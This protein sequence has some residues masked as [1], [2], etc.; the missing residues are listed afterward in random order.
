MDASIAHLSDDFILQIVKVHFLASDGIVCLDEERIAPREADVSFIFRVLVQDLQH[1][2]ETHDVVGVD[3]EA[4]NL[5]VGELRGVGR[6]NVAYA[7]EQRG[8]PLLRREPFVVNIA[9]LYILFQR[10]QFEIRVDF[11]GFRI[12][13]VAAPLNRK[14]SAGHEIDAISVPSAIGQVVA[15]VGAVDRYAFAV[16]EASNVV[17]HHLIVPKRRPSVLLALVQKLPKRPPDRRP[18]QRLARNGIVVRRHSFGVHLAQPLGPLEI[19]RVL[20]EVAVETADFVGLLPVAAPAQRL[21]R[22]LLGRSVCLFAH[23]VLA[24]DDGEFLRFFVASSA[25]FS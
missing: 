9:A 3:V 17:P 24:G 10:H 7:L 16:L 25:C 5:K 18:E 6:L 14:S 1:A 22:R 19:A 20:R 13:S 21:H 2:F 4:Q 23:E 8:S 12:I 15:Q 11:G